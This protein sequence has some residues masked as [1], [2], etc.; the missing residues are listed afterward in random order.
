MSDIKFRSNMTVELV[1]WMGEDQRVVE[2]AKVSTLGDRSRGVEPTEG[3]IDFLDRNR[4]G[5]P[6][7]HSV[8]TFLVE[9]PI[10]VAREFMRHRIASYN[11]ESGRYKVM[12]GVFYRPG[13]ERPLVQIGKAGEYRFQ[14]GTSEQYE[15]VTDLFQLAADTSYN[16]YQ[17]MLDA[18]I[19][20]E[21]AR[22]VLP[23][24]LYTSFYVTMNARGLMN[25][26]SLRV[27]DETAAYPST[28]LYEIELVARQMEQH[29]AEKM[30]MTHKSFVRNGRVS[31]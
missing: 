14:P 27:G 24:Q 5:S 21:V 19:A 31:P 25:F 17:T 4:H 6:F 7:E 13:P 12:K 22:D 18:G 29:F 20:R 2:A 30:P 1:D 11:E 9:C 8:F 3:F 10:F 26:L 23:F 15:L 16:L 28:P